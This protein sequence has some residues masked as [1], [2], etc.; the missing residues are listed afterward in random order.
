MFS[1]YALNS[2]KALASEYTIV[3]MR[4]QLHRMFTNIMNNCRGNVTPYRPQFPTE[5]APT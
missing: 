2:T 3:L 4:T 5:F 1:V